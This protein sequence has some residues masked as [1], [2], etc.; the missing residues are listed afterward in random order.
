MAPD[1]ADVPDPGPVDTSPL[2]VPG[3]SELRRDIT[4]GVDYNVIFLEAWFVVKKYHPSSGPECLRSFLS[5]G[6]RKNHPDLH[7]IAIR[8]CTIGEY[9]Y[10]TCKF[11]RFS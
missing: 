2:F 1:A 4:I 9:N 5:Y 6:S 3:S 7:P 11:V 10:G 8:L